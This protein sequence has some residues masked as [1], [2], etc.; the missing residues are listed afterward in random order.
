M[1]KKTVLDVCCG[2]R[3]MWFDKN[4][5]KALF[6]DNRTVD[7]ILCYGRTL[8]VKP[9]VLADFTALP[10]EDNQFPL[11]V[12]DPPHLRRAGENSWLRNKYGVLSS[13]WK[14]ILRKGFE[15]C[16]RVLAPLGTLIFK[17]CEEQIKLKDVLSCTDEKPLFGNRRGTTIWIVF[18][19]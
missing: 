5:E 14:D 13:D 2:S 16:F 11:I 6:I 12:F 15:E 17:W 3:M 18:Q 1:S 8:I 4:N 19:K 10:F 9:D 7:T